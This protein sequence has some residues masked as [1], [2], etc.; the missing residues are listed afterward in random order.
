MLQSMGSERVGHDCV[1]EL[2]IK[3]H[4][5]LLIYIYIYIYVCMTY[6]VLF[7]YICLL[8]FKKQIFFILSFVIYLLIVSITNLQ[9]M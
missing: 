2:I 7:V 4:S 8:L 9:L 5:T 1:T 6:C 3:G